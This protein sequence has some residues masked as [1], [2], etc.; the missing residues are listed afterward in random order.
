MSGVLACCA[1]ELE[2]HLT[3]RTSF[4]GGV[5]LGVGLG[6]ALLRRLGRLTYWSSKVIGL[7][8]CAAIRALVEAC[9]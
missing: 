3:S 4:S 8:G 1:A 2:T 7:E 5:A 9:K 6:E